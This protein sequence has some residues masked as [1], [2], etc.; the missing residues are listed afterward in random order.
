MTARADSVRGSGSML[1]KAD[2]PT[3]CPVVKYSDVPASPPV[4]ISTTPCSA[5]NNA[6]VVGGSVG[7]GGGAGWAAVVS[8][9]ALNNTGRS[10][11]VESEGLLAD[12]TNV[13]EPALPPP[14]PHSPPGTHL[15]N[16]VGVVLDVPDI[17][18]GFP[19]A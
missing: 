15:A 19:S 18:Q 5:G 4:V 7:W 1:S 16:Q 9:A 12:T 11:K 10:A 13:V 14:M 2:R 17:V 8:G 6:G 3:T